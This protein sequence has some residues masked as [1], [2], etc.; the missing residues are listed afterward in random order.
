MRILS[1]QQVKL[2]SLLMCLIPISATAQPL[3]G[4]DDGNNTSLQ[5]VRAYDDLSVPPGQLTIANQ[6]ARSGQLRVDTSSPTSITSAKEAMQT[7]RDVERA[8]KWFSAGLGS[9]P[10]YGSIGG[11]ALESIAEHAYVNPQ[12]TRIRISLLNAL[13]AERQA[14]QSR[15]SQ[16][17]Q[18]HKDSGDT[19]AYLDATSKI[20]R[21]AFSVVLANGEAM[22]DTAD[23][24]VRAV[25]AQKQSELAIALTLNTLE[26]GHELAENDIRQSDAIATLSDEMRALGDTVTELRR[27]NQIRFDQLSDTTSHL[28]ILVNEQNDRLGVTDKQIDELRTTTEALAQKY[29]VIAE[30]VSNNA[31]GIENNKQKIHKMQ[32]WAAEVDQWKADFEQKVEGHFSALY[33]NDA[34]LGARITEVEGR[35]GFV[36]NAM[37]AM[38]PP[39]L[40]LQ[41]LQN[42]DFMASAFNGPK[43]GVMREEEIGKAR[44]ELTAQ[45]AQQVMQKAQTII[46]GLHQAAGLLGYDSE[47]LNDVVAYFNMTTAIGMATSGDPAAMMNALSAV[48]SFFGDPPPD[49]D[50]E[51]FE[52]IMAYLG[53][54]EQKLDV[55][56]EQL[57]VIAEN[58]AKLSEQIDSSRKEMHARFNDVM[59]G[60]DVIYTTLTVNQNIV[61]E[62]SLEAA[63]S[64]YT[65]LVR[66]NMG[67][68]NDDSLA[69]YLLARDMFSQGQFSELLLE[70][71]AQNAVKVADSLF[72]PSKPLSAKWAYSAWFR[73][74]A[75]PEH[76]PSDYEKPRLSLGVTNDTAYHLYRPLYERILQRTAQN[77]EGSNTDLD[78]ALSLRVF[79]IAGS[80]RGRLQLQGEPRRQAKSLLLS[81][82]RGLNKN[83]TGLLVS[84]GAIAKYANILSDTIRLLTLCYDPKTLTIFTRDQLLTDLDWPEGDYKEYVDSL[85]V[86]CQAIEIAMVQ[87]AI[88]AGHGQFDTLGYDLSVALCYSTDQTTSIDHFAAGDESRVRETI[89]LLVRNPMLWSNLRTV[90]L[91]EWFTDRPHR[92]A[93]LHSQEIEVFREAF[94]PDWRDNIVEAGGAFELRYPYVNTAGLERHFSLRLNHA[95]DPLLYVAPIYYELR[96]TRRKLAAQLAEYELYLSDDPRDVDVRRGLAAAVF[97]RARQAAGE[98]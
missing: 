28:S 21:D 17:W 34:V 23:A 37:Y 86:A 19:R 49:A 46:N 43:G 75:P 93:F 82:E 85:L 6:M 54:I 50:Q 5:V 87:Q 52:A 73:L 71:Y 15:L 66:A 18:T 3:P 44:A 94:P 41:M 62:I 16:A 4:E 51:R 98:P 96:D 25:V 13:G 22:G 48:A 47:E 20:Y 7:V 65:I 60:L 70:R 40:R 24:E 88:I 91:G 90:L 2:Y 53:V 11:Q 35:V 58:Q 81:R 76:Y 45:E 57:D 72:E 84:P 95:Y 42:P 63:D 83:R 26:L 30:V 12:T 56:I 89:E 67:E 27:G 14:Y 92:A 80:Y 74:D 10:G 61:G 36:E 59:D 77:A 39:E 38:A 79:D 97:L 29:E 68:F 8:A 55:I 33:H 64:M 1:V 32:T 31:E 69:W 9:L 78:L